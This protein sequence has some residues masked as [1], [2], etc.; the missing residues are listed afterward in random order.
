[1]SSTRS[2]GGVNLTNFTDDPEKIGRNNNRRRS[3]NMADAGNEDPQHQKPE[4]HQ[5]DET[6]RGH[7]NPYRD[8]PTWSGQHTTQ[9]STEEWTWLGNGRRSHGGVSKAEAILLGRHPSS[10]E[11][12]RTSLPTH[13][14]WGQDIPHQLLKNQV[15]NPPTQKGP[16]RSGTTKSNPQGSTR[17]RL[18]TENQDHPM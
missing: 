15:P 2:K 4:E 13:Q 14:G 1:M 8:V 9:P 7:S 10:P 12:L 17:R 5:E 11:N 18:A 16:G 6:G 3:R